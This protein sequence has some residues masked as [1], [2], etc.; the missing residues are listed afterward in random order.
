MTTDD[1]PYIEE[2]MAAPPVEFSG[3]WAELLRPRYLISTITLC[4]GVALF[5]F[6]FIVNFMGRFRNEK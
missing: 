4:L 3:G 5:A 6:K 1:I 2:Q